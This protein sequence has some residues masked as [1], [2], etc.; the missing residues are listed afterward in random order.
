MS[1]QSEIVRFLDHADRCI[2]RYIRAKENLIALL[3][4]QGKTIIDQAITGQ[5]D[6][7]TGKPYPSYKGTN[8][9]WLPAAP[10]QWEV[11]RFGKAIDLTVGF[12]FKSEGFSQSE[13]DVRLLRGVNVSS[14]GLRWE[15]TVRWPA[16]DVG[17]LSDYRL[18]VG[19]I[20]LGMDR[21]II[22]SGVRVA[23]V[24]ETDVPSLLLQ[25]VARIRPDETRLDPEFAYLLLR[26]NSFLNYLAPIF[27]GISVPHL[28][29]GQIRNFPI[30]L[31]NVSEQRKISR[32]LQ[33][34]TRK[35]QAGVE[36]AQRQVA[37]V[38]EFRARLVADVV[39]GRTDVRDAASM[40]PDTGTGVEESGNGGPLA[41]SVRDLGEVGLAIAKSAA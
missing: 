25:R 6:V 27:T 29:P 26:G 19:D 5:F 30:A 23:V 21:P 40:L 16:S 34:S 7:R 18:E 2:R 33:S 12:P 9:Q 14:G 28:S 22:G 8:I 39:T 11:L 13:E 20:I 24:G 15:E 35:I 36:A 4:E 1:E 10:S 3:E 17:A 41:K 37:L 32:Y 38:R 31:P